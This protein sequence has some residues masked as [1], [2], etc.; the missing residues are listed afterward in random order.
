MKREPL[1]LKYTRN[2]SPQRRR[3]YAEQR[4]VFLRV[5]LREICVS[6]VKRIKLKLSLIPT[7]KLISFWLMLVFL[8]LPCQRGQSQTGVLI[9]STKPAPD[10]SILSLQ[11]MNVDICID[12][13]TA[14]IR[15]V[16]IFDNKTGQNQEGK[17]L[18]ALPD[19]A[20]VADFAVWEGD[21][22]VP[23]VMMERRRANE[24]YG[25]IKEKLIDPG[26]LQQDDEMGGNSA[27]SAKVF[28]ITPYGTKRIEME[29][30]ENLPIENLSSGFTFPLKP[31]W[32]ETQK[33]GEFNLSVCVYN[34]Y[35]ISGIE[36]NSQKFPLEISK[37]TENEFEAEFHARDYELSEDFSFRYRLNVPESQFSFIAYRAPE[38][39]SAYDLRNPA[40]AEQNRDGFFEAR[41]I[42]KENSAEKTH[43]RRVLL[44]L[45]T[46]LSMYGNKLKQSV[47]AVDF[48]LHNLNEQDEFNLILFGNESNVFSEKALPATPE[49]IENA[50]GFIKNSYL[51]GGTNLKKAF[52]K[53]IEL[54]E[55]FSAGER[56]FVLVSDAN[57]TK[58]TTKI[59]ALTDLFKTKP[60]NSI[61]LYAFAPGSDANTSLLEEL[62]AKTHGYFT[63]VRE[64]ED[65]SAA[66]KIFF[67]KVGTPTIENLRFSSAD[68]GNFYQVY[69]TA[70]NSFNGSSFSF[71]GRYRAPKQS[72][73]INFSAQFGAFNLALAQNVTLPEFADFHKHLPRLWAKARIDALVREINLNGER[74]DYI[75]E[76]IHLSQKY[77][78]VS[79]YTAFVAAPRALLRPRLIQP[80][81]PV[82]RV[83]TDERVAKVFAVLPF[84]ETL[85]LK[86]LESE[87]VWET[88]FLAPAWM[89]D[90]VYSCRL[91]LTDAGGNGF[92]EK[93]TF[94]V[95]SRAPKVKINLP[96][97]SVKTGE[98]IKIRVSSDSDTARLT[99]KLYGAKPIEL[100]WSKEEKASV[101]IIRIPE[102][103]APGKYVLTVTAEDFA[104][105]QNSEEI[106]LE[107][108]G[109]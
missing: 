7:K 36:Y 88:R 74:E 87:G 79:P 48:F 13:Q 94:V 97:T 38:N 57:P 72:E 41:T 68:T 96:Q 17:F 49:T 71:V 1:L 39:I 76:I 62:T 101:G 14:T 25:E 69:P 84:G 28:P 104:H 95:D 70:E 86:Y 4:R 66:L 12:N 53:A 65:V 44:L 105:N 60:A 21:A 22:R 24:V 43:P 59:G 6:A 56:S 100:R 15:V 11:T 81:D 98:E 19:R 99:A 75:N 92:E 77:K 55:T 46:S 37:Q 2:F 85:P 10:A 93:K 5:S 107:I 106:V 26:I 33:V 58:E 50:L 89:P 40:S 102:Q 109:R 78:I 3:D 91:V 63:K 32:G 73:T 30:T 23:G 42:F 9:P 82:I 47:E 80:G 61:K 34:E 29:Y 16:Q 103:V 31:N 54:S 108:S 83:K 67:S 51:G 52:E 45:D 27:F 64:T 35:S 18:F 20:S 90:G 8:I